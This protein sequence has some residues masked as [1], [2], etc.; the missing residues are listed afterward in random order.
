MQVAF[1]NMINRAVFMIKCVK[2]FVPLVLLVCGNHGSD[3]SYFFVQATFDCWVS[4]SLP[5]AGKSVL[6]MIGGGNGICCRI[7]TGVFTD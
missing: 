1:F 2:K 3:E 5:F 4:I 6:I 7:G